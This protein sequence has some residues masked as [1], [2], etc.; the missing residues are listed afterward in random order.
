MSSPAR[1]S[2]IL[3]QVQDDH[4]LDAEASAAA[5]AFI[6]SGQVPEADIA[7]FLTA[8][9]KRSPTVDEITGAAT[10]MRNAMTSISAPP[11]AIDVCGTGGDGHGTFNVSTA[12]AFV[13][14]ACGVPVAKHGNRS[15][16]SPTGAADVLEQLGVRTDLPPAAAEKMLR[17][18]NFC[19]LFAPAYHPAMK[20]V[21]A[22]RR[23]LGFRTIFNL[24]GPIANPARVRRQ[25]IGVYAR[26]MIVPI[27]NVL[28]ALGTDAAWVVHGDDG[29]DELTTTTSSHVAS[30]SDGRISEFNVEPDDIGA[31]RT[32]LA[33]LRG[34]DASDNAAVIVA[35]LGGAHGAFRDI[36]LLNS[37]AALVVAGKAESLRAGAALATNAIDAGAAEEALARV[38][39]A[40]KMAA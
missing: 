23:A 22:V 30:L 18:T 12:A 11:G 3:K 17:E 26:E 40:S 24:L 8:L 19:F 21:A 9:A 16:S 14:A 36:V 4:A 38:V 10:A 5:F 33:D 7:A 35:L 20:H 32:T 39:A 34:G 29:L 15:I 13:V 6:M 31:R 25:L 37:G 27:A 2:A 1:F 28:K